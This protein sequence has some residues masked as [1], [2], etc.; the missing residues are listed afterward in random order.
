MHVGPIGRSRSYLKE[1]EGASTQGQ[2]VRARE[3]RDD[4]VEKFNG[5]GFEAGRRSSQLSDGGREQPVLLL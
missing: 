2:L 5:K 4:C 1:L 3:E